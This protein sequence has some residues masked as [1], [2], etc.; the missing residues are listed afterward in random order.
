M[1]KPH[2]PRCGTTDVGKYKG[3]STE[4]HP[5]LKSMI[6]DDDKWF[7]KEKCCDCQA[8]E[9]LPAR[10]VRHGHK[11]ILI[12]SDKFL[13]GKKKK[14]IPTWSERCEKH[15][16]HRGIVTSSM[17]QDRMQE[18]IDELRSALKKLRTKYTRLCNVYDLKE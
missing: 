5:L 10:R 9:K 7:Y 18:E 16:D 4:N 13:E 3:I 2:C 11:T 8:H 17:I 1:I 6:N 12:H 15:P 14:K